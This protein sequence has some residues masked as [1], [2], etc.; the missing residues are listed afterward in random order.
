MR[1]LRVWWTWQT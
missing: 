1:T